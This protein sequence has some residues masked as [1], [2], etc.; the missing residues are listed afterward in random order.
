MENSMFQLCPN[1]ENSFDISRVFISESNPFNEIY[2]CNTCGLLYKPILTRGD[3]ER[4]RSYYRVETWE[5]QL[6]AHQERLKKLVQRVVRE[7]KIKP[8]DLILDVGAGVGI[9]YEELSKIVPRLTRYFAVEPACGVASELKRKYPEIFVL[10]DDMDNVKL[11]EG[12]FK[13]IF[14]CGVDY[15][16]RD[17]RH[18]FEKIN[19]LL[20]EDGLVVIQRNVFIDQKGWIGDEIGSLRDMFMKNPIMRNWFH[21]EQYV[22]F[23]RRMFKVKEVWR[24]TQWF[25]AEGG[26]KFESFCVN[27]ICGKVNRQMREEGVR[28]YHE[29]NAYYVERLQR[30]GEKCLMI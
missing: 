10:N 30:G 21:S 5:K 29:V 11:P 6:S 22:E 17:L 25:E 4:V 13:V 28:S 27:L 20:V 1:C 12:K 7:V 2:M 3:L 15:L 14:V 23:V 24:E 26:A 16:F 18:S 8:S 19:S 9:L